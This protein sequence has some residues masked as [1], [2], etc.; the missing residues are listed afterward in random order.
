MKI[1]IGYDSRESECFDVCK[2]SIL[3]NTHSSPEIHPIK[4]SDLSIYNRPSDPLASTE[5]TYSRFLCPYL[6]NYKGWALF[7]DCDFLFLEDVTTLFNFKKNEYAVM[8]CKHDYTPSTD[9]KMDGK[10]QTVYP[11]KNWSSLMLWN[12]EH[13][14]NKLLTPELINSQTGKFLHRFEWLEDEDIGSLPLEWNWLVG[15]YKEPQDGYPKALHY[16]EGGPWFEKYKNCE[17]SQIW[18]NVSEE[19]QNSRYTR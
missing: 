8:V 18:L 15:W 1:Y 6:Q 3:I 16:T 2:H 19:L 4:L 7:C 5:F 10:T 11:R 17:Y 9:V 13:P 14:K 12:C